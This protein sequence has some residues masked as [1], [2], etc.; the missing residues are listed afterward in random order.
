[1]TDG[2]KLGRADVDAALKAWPQ[3]ERAPEEWEKSARS[4]EAK[5]AGGAVSARAPSPGGAGDLLRP[6]LPPGLEEVQDSAPSKMQTTERERDRRSLQDL[7]K[8][9][10]SPSLTPAPPRASA[11]PP[12]SA[13]GP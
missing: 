9:A 11:P 6:P 7:A 2:K 12:P 8:L 5:I 3:V 4:I 1:M 13:A 10:S